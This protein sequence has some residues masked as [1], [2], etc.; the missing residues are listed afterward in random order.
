MNKFLLGMLVMFL[1][2]NRDR[3]IRGYYIVIYGKHVMDRALAIRQPEIEPPPINT[4]NEVKEPS[5]A[6]LKALG[7]NVKEY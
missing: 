6:K 5:L 2:C 4:E 3:V 1:W 7:F